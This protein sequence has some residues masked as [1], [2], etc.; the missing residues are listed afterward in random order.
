[1]GDIGNS[2]LSYGPNAPEGFRHQWR[3]V[4]AICIEALASNRTAVLEN[5]VVLPR[6]HNPAGD[7]FS[8]W[9]R[10]WDL[11]TLCAIAASPEGEV[12]TIPVNVHWCDDIYV[13]LGTAAGDYHVLSPDEKISQQHAD[14]PVLCRNMTGTHCAGWLNVTSDEPLFLYPKDHLKRYG[15]SWR[16]YF[17][18]IGSIWLEYPRLSSDQL[19]NLSKRFGFE[20]RGYDIQIVAM[21][22]PEIVAVLRQ[23]LDCLGDDF[24]SMHIRKPDKGRLDRQFFYDSVKIIPFISANLELAGMTKDRP[25]FVMTNDRDKSFISLLKNRYRI[26]TASDFSCFRQLLEK[27]PADDYMAYYIEQYIGVMSSRFYKY[28]RFA[29]ERFVFPSAEPSLWP[30]P[31]LIQFHNLLPFIRPKKNLPQPSYSQFSPFET[32]VTGKF[33]HLIILFSRIAVQLSMVPAAGSLLDVGVTINRKL[34]KLRKRL[35]AW[36]RGGFSLASRRDSHARP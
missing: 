16:S 28:P 25:L 8:R 21:P 9:D 11:S 29:S 31:Q 27:Y 22:T 3:N 23:I 5:R 6:K 12:K 30:R 33:Y 35:R 17:K 10:Y 7:I 20:C 18:G 24:W 13:W 15:E 19:H 34:K 4:D 2:F 36:G 14:H 32:M 1:M 26:V